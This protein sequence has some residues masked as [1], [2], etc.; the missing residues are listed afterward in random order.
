M[1]NAQK[2]A[3]AVVLPLLALGAALW[4]QIWAQ[5]GRF[6][7]L[8]HA[9]RSTGVSAALIP[10]GLYLLL[11][12]VWISLARWEARLLGRDPG[13]GLRE[14]LVALLPL[15]FLYLAPVAATR[16]FTRADLRGR[17]TTLLLMVAAAVVVLKLAQYHRAL[18][19][20]WPGL[21]RALAKWEALPRRRRIAALFLAAMIAYYAAVLALVGR[22]VTFSGDEPNYLMTSESLLADRDIDLANNYAGKDWFRFY[23]RDDQPRLKL[24]IY[25]REGRKGSGAVYPINMPGV[26]VLLL[27]HYALG[28]LFSGPA[29]TFVIKTG[30]AF[31]GALFAVQ[32]YLFALERWRRERIALALWAAV[33]F[34]GPV[35]FFSTHLY[36]EIPI[37]FM[38]LLIY[39]KATSAAP[40]RTA[41]LAGLGALLGTF[42]WFGIK[43]NFVF[44]PLLLVAG[45]HLIRRHRLGR[46]AAAFLLPA[47]LGNAAFFL[48]TYMLYGSAS[49]LSVYEGVMTPEQA[50]AYKDMIFGVP[51]LDRLSAFFDYFL[52]QRD[53]LLLYAP[54]YFFALLGFV[55]MFRRARREFW[56][57]LFIAAPFVL[58]YAFF[59]HRQGYAPPGRV[60]T[61]LIWTAAVALGYFLAHADR[62]GIRVAFRTAVFLSVGIAVLLLAH[63][64]FLYQPTT[65][66]FTERPGDLWVWLGNA[67]IF[68]PPL[69]PSFIKV[70]NSGYLPDY[71]WILGTVG[72]V[73]AYALSKR[74]RAPG[75]PPL[76]VPG[77]PA[78][79]PG[80]VLTLLAAGSILWVLEPRT[81]LYPYV[82][83]A[84]APGTEV[85]YATLPLGKGVIIK[86]NGELY[87]H[88]EKTYR[89]LFATKKKIGRAKLV[90][91]ADRGTYDIAVRFFDLPLFEDRTADGRKEHVFEPPA[92]RTWRRFQVYELTVELKHLTAENMKLDPFAFAVIPEE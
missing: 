86:P 84:A 60:L 49:P 75:I 51:L 34:T 89:V 15:A 50:A 55:E 4:A 29:L 20:R 72:F 66:E 80:L 1:T 70:D 47:L 76:R 73:L 77:R 26:S 52:D 11:A 43:Y 13:S 48:T 78:A 64:P 16:Y 36:P 79:V 24:G 90:Y 82:T 14:G 2:A 46:K 91:G 62:P 10:A 44:W 35:L 67:R 41:V 33:A 57:L 17:L 71:L 18:G 38:A 30:L 40:P 42:A 61:P 32:V 22:G 6:T 39:R 54:L 53:G 59:T 69:L 58:N 37:A 87:F 28:R 88:V 19:G 21:E 23:D 85:A 92:A 27:P 7:V 5:S 31:W 45:W 12:V 65:H 81:S 56:S 25:G 74:K 68:L 8:D 63:P 83:T 9:F 3:A